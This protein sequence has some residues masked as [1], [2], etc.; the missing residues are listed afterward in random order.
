MQY[1]DGKKYADNKTIS[2]VRE[3]SDGTKLFYGHGKFDEWCVYYEGRG[4]T[5]KA[6]SDSEYF[7]VLRKLATKH[8]K[9]K[10]FTDFVRVFYS[11]DHNVLPGNSEW[12]YIKAFSD[13]YGEDALT[14]EKCFETLL[15]TMVA[16]ERKEGAVVGKYIKLV[17]GYEVINTF[18]PVKTISKKYNGLKAYMIWNVCR[19][20]HLVPQNA[21]LPRQRHLLDAKVR[22][23]SDL[24]PPVRS[25]MSA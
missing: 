18:L 21:A 25:C 2:C 5:R 7:T 3:F 13:T 14:A 19:K 16:E 8:G 1:F 24:Y 10:V 4:K 12:E 23:I 11:A 17:A 22:S 6:L 20:Y 15:Y 9:N